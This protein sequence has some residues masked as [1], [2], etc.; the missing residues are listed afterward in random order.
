MILGE[1]HGRAFWKS[2]DRVQA[3]RR[4]GYALCFTAATILKSE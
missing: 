1:R 2:F 3:V 4:F